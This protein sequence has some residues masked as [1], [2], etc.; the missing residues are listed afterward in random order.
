MTN[1][2]L[3]EDDPMISLIE[4]KIIERKGY[5]VSISS[6][7]E[8]ALERCKA[9]DFDLILMDID[10]GAGINGID[11]AEKILEDKDIPLVFLS[12]NT[13]DEILETTEKIT[14]YGYIVKSSG[15]YVLLTSIKMALKLHRSNVKL[16]E[17]EG[18]YKYLF[19]SNPHPMWIYEIESLAFLEVNDAAIYHYGYT[20][21]E[22]LS[23]KISDIRPLEDVEPLL[24]N[25]ENLSEGMDDAGVWTH[26]TKS[27]QP[28]QVQIYSHTI[29]WND[30]RAEVVIAYKI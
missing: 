30:K 17:R 2:L 22:F 16:Q 5:V 27:G 19:M 3:V 1:I 13:E 11:A 18:E 20:Y 29:T 8:D 9:E 23:M 28:I 10:L 24:R 14:P 26:L 15:A 21:D 25:I 12:S 7:G 6:T 4:K